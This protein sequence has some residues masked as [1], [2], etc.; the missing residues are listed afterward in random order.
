MRI[1]NMLLTLLATL[2]VTANGVAAEK[3]VPSRVLM[4]TQS[5]GFVHGS[6]RRPK[7]DEKNWPSPRLR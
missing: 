3:V 4:L 7:G 2:A 1:T 5:A 6:V